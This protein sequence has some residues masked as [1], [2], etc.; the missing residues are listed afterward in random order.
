M[1]KASSPL[2]L[3]TNDD[4]IGSPGLR[5]VVAA[6]GALGQV[7]VAAPSSQ[8]SGAGRSMPACSSGR[9]FEYSLKVNGEE[10]TA[11]AVEGTPAQVVQHAILELTPRPPD[12]VISGINYGE[13]LGSGITVSG[14]VGAALEATSFGTMALASSLGVE[15]Q[16]HLS[17]STEVDFRVAAHFTAH[18]AGLLLNRSLPFDVDLVKLDVPASATVE[19]PWRLTRVSRERYFMPLAARE[20][21]LSAPG[22]IDYECRLDAER[23]EPDSD[24]YAFIVDQVVSVSPISFDLT[25]RAELAQVDQVLSAD[26]N[27]RP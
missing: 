6:V 25:S 3:V 14:T 8:Q 9:I 27:G 23:L 4:R 22:P 24:I 2:I 11:Y 7:I 26:G 17:H 18:F 12:L 21:A 5:A 10:T 15:K 20:G 19:T 16:H 1:S 13:N